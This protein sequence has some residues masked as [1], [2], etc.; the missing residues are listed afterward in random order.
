MAGCISFYL[1]LGWVDDGS[2]EPTLPPKDVKPDPATRCL[3]M[4]HCR[5]NHKLAF[6]KRHLSNRDAMEGNDDFSIGIRNPHLG[7]I[8]TRFVNQKS[9]NQKMRRF[10]MEKKAEPFLLRFFVSP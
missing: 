2:I 1:V 5:Y 4:G 6:H 3:K 9:E 10:L 8:S 7:H